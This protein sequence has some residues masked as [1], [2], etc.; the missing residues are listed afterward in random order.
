MILVVLD[1]NI[2]VSAALSASGNE[3]G[4]I[5]ALE[6]GRLRLCISVPMLS[7][8]EDVLSRPKFDRVRPRVDGVLATVKN[9]ALMTQPTPSG[10]VSPDPDDT[11]FI[12]CAISAGAAILITGNK[13]HFPEQFYGTAKVVNARQLLIRLAL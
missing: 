11:C 8:Y 1:T 10:F 2:L 6:A 4:V 13:R 3:A 9:G 7:E 12:D 5:R